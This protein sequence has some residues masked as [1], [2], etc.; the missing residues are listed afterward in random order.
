MVIEAIR[1]PLPPVGA[2]FWGDA[3]RRMFAERP[4]EPGHT[5]AR[6]AAVLAAME[7]GQSLASIK[8]IAGSVRIAS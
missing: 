3:M 5:R 7:M 1:K 4:G 6:R 8:R 2:S